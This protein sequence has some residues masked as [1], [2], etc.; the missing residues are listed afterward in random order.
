MKSLVIAA[1]SSIS[2]LATALNAAAQSD[3][4]IGQL[5]IE[6]PWT[7]ATPGGAKVGVGY[8]AIANLS[9]EEDRL[10]TARSPIAE[11]VEI[12]AM[13]MNGGVMR[14][15]E[16]KQ[17][18]LLKPRA[19][20]EL[21]PGG[22]HL[23]LIGLKRPIKEGDELALE[24]TFE[25]AG[26]AKLSMLAAGIGATKSPYG[27]IGAAGGSNS[28]TAGSAPAGHDPAAKGSAKGSN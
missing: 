17:G 24:L 23:M 11:R 7:R 20:T 19:I 4:K 2:L 16:L 8:V 25:K 6:A 28:G 18:L 15:R 3:V 14:M 26:T 13:M 10:R 27:G 1:A 21:R 12:H 22:Y 5:V 9:E